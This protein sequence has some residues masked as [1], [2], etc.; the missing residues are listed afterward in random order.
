MSCNRSFCFLLR[1]GQTTRLFSNIGSKSFSGS[2]T[3]KLLGLD[4]FKQIS[5]AQRWTST[6]ATSRNL[7]PEEAS[8]FVDN[9]SPDE[10]EN[11]KNALTQYDS[12]QA[13][14]IKLEGE[15]FLLQKYF[16][17]RKSLYIN[18]FLDPVCLA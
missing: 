17:N 14:R 15:K 11:L 12:S 5:R 2:S 1:C 4:N 18:L 13:R 8:E 7:S 6:S 9:L 3:V 16:A 10:R